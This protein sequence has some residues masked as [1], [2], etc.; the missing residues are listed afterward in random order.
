M[1]EV[2]AQ[3]KNKHWELV[4]R[5]QVPPDTD[6]LPAIWTMHRKQNLIT[7]KIKCHKARLNIHGGKQVYG[8][9]Y[10]ETYASVITWFAI[11]FMIILVIILGWAIQQIDF[12]QAY[13][14]AP[15]EWDM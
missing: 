10:Y 11:R 4:R 3:V 2:E 1:N 9:N 8:T 6:I 5:D 14:Q 15:N 7:D 12:V 13:A